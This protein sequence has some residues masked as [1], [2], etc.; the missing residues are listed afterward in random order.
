MGVLRNIGKSGHIEKI[1][2][3]CPSQPD[4]KFILTR[5]IQEK[6]I[7]AGE[8]V[9]KNINE[10]DY[11]FPFDLEVTKSEISR[12]LLIGSCLTALYHEGFSALYPNV[13]FDYIP[14]NFVSEIPEH[15]PVPI[16]SYNFQYIQIPLRSVLSD[17]V[18]WGQNF[19][20]PE[21]CK[22]IQED[23]YNIIDAMLETAMAYNSAIKFLH[24]FLILL[25]LREVPLQVLMTL[26]QRKICAGL[27][28]N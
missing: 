26:G 24:S 1:L 9:C 20:N 27:S 12:V 23:A 4:T 10:Q 19:L 3:F 7:I 6:I 22:N 18:I 15:P 13:A 21:F 17:K 8:S 25:F 11:L 2:L 14:Y 28:R 16:D 5:S